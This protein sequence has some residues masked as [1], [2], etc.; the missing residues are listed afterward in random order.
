VSLTPPVAWTALTNNV[1]G[2]TNF[3]ADPGG[4]WTH[5]DLNSTNYSERYYRAAQ[6]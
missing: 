4:I 6:Y 2:T 3:V 5:T 1:N